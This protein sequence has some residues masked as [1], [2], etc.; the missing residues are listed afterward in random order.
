MC[1]L[2]VLQIKCDSFPLIVHM[3]TRVHVRAC[4]CTK[5][6]HNQCASYMH[7]HNSRG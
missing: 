5:R 6:V 7:R 3:M 1:V 2:V 4:A